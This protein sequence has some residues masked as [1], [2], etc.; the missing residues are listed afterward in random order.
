[1]NKI[2]ITFVIILLGV[3]AKNQT[4]DTIPQEGF[5]F[6]IKSKITLKLV[7]ADS[8]KYKYYILKYEPFDEIIDTYENDKYISKNLEENT[9][10]LIFCV[11]THGDTEKE[12]KE[13]YQSLLLIKNG[14]K[15]PLE[16]EAD[17]RVYKKEEFEPT[18]V[19]PLY[20][21]VKNMEMWPYLIEE[22]GLHGFRQSKN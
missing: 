19:V 13:N 10:E 5:A 17:M 14:T 12:K 1:M 2:F 9:I 3:S 16:Y 22:I 18:S 20:P 11:G 8:L 15:Y 6:P 7:P 21:N 4:L